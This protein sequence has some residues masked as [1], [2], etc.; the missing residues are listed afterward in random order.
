MIRL[1]IRGKS[2]GG[3]RIL[4]PIDLSVARGET[5]ALMGPSGVGKSTLLAIAAGLDTDVEGTVE[6]QGRL[7]V[8]FQEPALLKWRRAVQ[9]ITLMTGASD[10]RARALMEEMGLAGLERSFPGQMS[11]GQ[12]RRL[13]IAR[14]LAAEP[15]VLLLDEPFASLDPDRVG[16]IAARV[17][18]AARTRAIACL[19]VTHDR[20]EAALLA[21]RILRL[22]GSPA[23]LCPDPPRLVANS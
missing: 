8:V 18:H 5:V 1:A 2:H 7:A 15:E 6:C 19:L 4:G 20:A 16:D 11:L 3:R 9:N 17:R 21:D 14:A 13:S 23:R 12:Q 22:E 10:A